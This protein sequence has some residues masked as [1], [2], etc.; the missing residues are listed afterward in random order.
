MNYLFGG[1]AV[2]C[3]IYCVY[4]FCQTQVLNN[5]LCIFH[6]SFESIQYVFFCQNTIIK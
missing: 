6:L 3:E 4:V 5:Y 1:V 2:T